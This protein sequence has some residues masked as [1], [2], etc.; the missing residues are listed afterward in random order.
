M[1]NEQ[2]LKPGGSPGC[3]ELTREEQQKGGKAS[4]RARKHRGDLRRACEALLKE[5]IMFDDKE[6]S[7]AEAAAL[8]MMKEAL[9]GNTKAFVALRDTAG[10]KPADKI[11]ATQ[12][13]VQKTI[14]LSS[15]TDEQIK[16]MLDKDI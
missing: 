12:K 5:T 14:D 13:V 3:Y 1:A 6:L 7:G 16:A 15:L 2:N 4:A 8:A 11:E 10:Q 9:L